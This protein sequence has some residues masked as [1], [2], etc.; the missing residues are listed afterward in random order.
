MMKMKEESKRNWTLLF[1]S[2]CILLL[3]IVAIFVIRSPDTELQKRIEDNINL[4]TPWINVYYVEPKHLFS[5]DD[6]WYSV[7][8]LAIHENYTDPQYIYH[9]RYD[10]NTD[11]LYYD[12][13]IEGI[14]VKNIQL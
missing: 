4:S 6:G 13:D 11:T 12:D 2:V 10:D 3:F 14:G 9:F 8:I 1:I 7:C 5:M